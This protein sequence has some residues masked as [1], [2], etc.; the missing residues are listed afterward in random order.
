MEVW[1]FGKELLDALMVL[2]NIWEMDI[3]GPRFERDDEFAEIR[4]LF[5]HF[6]FLFL[7]LTVT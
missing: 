6:S 7:A 1:A 5:D 3:R 4:Q 2:N